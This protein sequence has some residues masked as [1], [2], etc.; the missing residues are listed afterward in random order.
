MT[1][2]LVKELEKLQAQRKLD[3]DLCHVRSAGMGA[4]IQRLEDRVQRLRLEK[5]R[6]RILLRYPLPHR[7]RLAKAL[8][9]FLEQI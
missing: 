8:T 4:E 1:N 3:L 5:I 6:D 7:K 2:P 9:E